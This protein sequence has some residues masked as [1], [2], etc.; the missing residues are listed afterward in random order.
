MQIAAPVLAIIGSLALGAGGVVAVNAVAGG[1]GRTVAMA[2]AAAGGLAVLALSRRPIEVL[3]VA[4]ILLLGYNRQYFSFGALVGDHGSQGPFWIPADLPLVL[5]AGLVLL[6][7]TLRTTARQ[8]VSVGEV[9]PALPLL[10]TTTLSGLFA[11]RPDWAAFEWLRVVKFTGVLWLMLSLLD[12]PRWWIAVLALAAGG[13]AQAALGV[14]QVALRADQSLLSIVGLGRSIEGVLIENRARGMLGHPN[15]LG[16]YLLFLLP[17]LASAALHARDPRLRVAAGALG[18]VQFAGIIATKSRG[19]ITLALF[20]LLLVGLL[21]VR[22]R[23]LPVARA[24]ALA[25]AGSAAVATVGVAFSDQIRQRLTGDLRE[26]I[27][28]RTSYNE[29]AISMWADNP[30][31]GIGPNNIS[32]GL[33]RELPL[34]YGI[35]ADIARK[36]PLASVRGAAPVHNLYYLFLA[37]M[38]L[39][40]LVSLLLLLGAGLVASREASRRTDGVVRGIVSGLGVGIALQALQ[41]TIDFSLWWDPSFFTYALILALLARAPDERAPTT[42]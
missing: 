42:P 15:F 26:S 6:G 28:F 3:L 32:L 14:V 4:W 30:L 10:A 40:G 1:S 33:E 29:A 23:A 41:Q 9:W 18:V 34:I 7:R 37:E 16:P 25:I 36:A 8:A 21:A 39:A 31:F 19:P 12:R 17:M 20:G 13:A 35:V 5:L 27:D 11:E 2:M 38:G 24:I 22:H